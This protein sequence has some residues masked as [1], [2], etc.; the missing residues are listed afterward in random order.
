MRR[1]GETV[2]ATTAG[3]FPAQS[4]GTSTRKGDKLYVHVLNAEAPVVYLPMKAK[5][6]KAMAFDGG[7]KVAFR[8]IKAGGY[9]LDMGSVPDDID[10]I[11]EVTTE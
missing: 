1:Y 10:Y 11:I 4:W 5:I 7:E 8:P 6:K 3:D 2:Y 9:V